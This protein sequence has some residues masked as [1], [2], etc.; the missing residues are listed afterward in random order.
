MI[1]LED[2]VAKCSMSCVL[3]FSIYPSC[4]YINISLVHLYIRAKGPTMPHNHIYRV[5]LD[6]EDQWCLTRDNILDEE[7][8]YSDCFSAVE[9]GRKLAR[10]NQA[11]LIVYTPGG[12][13]HREYDYGYAR[14]CPQMPISSA[15]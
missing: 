15:L 3:H 9:E 12:S 7:T 6:E 10:Q 13:V 4:I 14:P 11:K 8:F 1:K 5:F 2:A